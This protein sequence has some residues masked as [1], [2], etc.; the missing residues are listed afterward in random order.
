MMLCSFKCI[1]PLNQWIPRQDGGHKMSIFQFHNPI[2]CMEKNNPQNINKKN[3]NDIKG[4]EGKD[5][6]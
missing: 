1:E 4:Y 5:N 3:V 2:T 6:T